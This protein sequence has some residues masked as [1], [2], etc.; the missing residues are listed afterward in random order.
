MT[1]GDLGQHKHNDIG[2]FENNKSQSPVY[3]LKLLYIF[4]SQQTPVPFSEIAMILYCGEAFRC[5]GGNA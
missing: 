2:D 4:S 1:K 3:R 5:F